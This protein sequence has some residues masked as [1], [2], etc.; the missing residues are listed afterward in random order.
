MLPD[1]GLSWLVDA[2]VQRIGADHL[3]AGLTRFGGQEPE[4]HTDWP[5]SGSSA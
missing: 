2:L 5:P 3:I 4:Q 1:S